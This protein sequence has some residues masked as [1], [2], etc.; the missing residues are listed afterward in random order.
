VGLIINIETA[1]SICSVALAK[2]GILLSQRETAEKNSHSFVLGTF[3]EEVIE[4]ANYKMSDLDAVAISS[5]PGSYTGLRIGASMAKGI[6]YSLDIPLIAVPTLK[7]MANGVNNHSADYLIPMI[8][9]RRMEVYAA[10]FDAFLTEIKPVEPVI[11]NE[12]SFLDLLENNKVAF[13]GDG[14]IKCKP[15]LKSEN[16][17]FF[18]SGMPSAGSMCSL[19]EQAFAKKQFEDTAYFEPFYL[20]EFQAKISKVKGLK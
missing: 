2:D 20:K 15:V 6:S 19:S 12:D 3:V 5:G 7:A 17:L 13:F 1:T 16:A 10:I 14:A 9:A 11:I 18:D 8:D 4:E